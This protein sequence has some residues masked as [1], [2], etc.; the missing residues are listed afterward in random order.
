ML[1]HIYIYIDIYRLHAEKTV[2]SIV[3]SHNKQHDGVDLVKGLHSR[4]C[5]PICPQVRLIS[6]SCL[7]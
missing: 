1:K 7:V 3:S 5:V 6:S 4:I 2:A